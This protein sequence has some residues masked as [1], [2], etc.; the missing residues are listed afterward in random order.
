MFSL[1]E[2]V[3][4]VTGA[5]SGI[6][7]AIAESFAA[8]GALVYV[9]DRDNASCNE[10]VSKIERQGGKAKSAVVDIR[11]EAECQALVKRV[12]AENSGRCDALVNNAGVGHVG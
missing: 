2:K 4:I 5:G 12:L 1:Q 11:Q 6:G 8:A 9:A 7:A 10:K 3:V